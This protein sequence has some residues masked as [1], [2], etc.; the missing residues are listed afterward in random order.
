VFEL[1]SHT[2]HQ[3]TGNFTRFL[4]E[5]ALRVEQ[6][7]AA[8]QKQSAEVAK[9]ERFVERFGAKA[10]KAA[11]ARS[12][13]KKLDKMNILTAPQHHRLPR[14]SLPPAPAGDMAAIKLV[15]VTAGWPD[16][17]D[18]LCNINLTV[19]RGR[20]IAVLGP[21][22]CGKS[23]L[24]AVLSGMLSPN[25][26]RRRVGDRIRIGSFTQDLAAELPG[27]L[28]ALEYVCQT[29]PIATEEQVRTTLGALGL[30][31]EAALRSIK[32]LSGGEKAR[33][34]LASLTTRPNNVLLLDEPT[35]HL[36]T[37]TVE[38]LVRALETYEGAMA[39]VT[40]DRYLVEQI[41]THVVNITG[42][43]LD[44]HEGILPGDLEP[45]STRQSG[46]KAVA[47]GS[48]AHA[49]RKREQRLRDRTVRRI[50]EIE[51][52][53]SCL[54]TEISDLD[55][56]LATSGVDYALLGTQRKQKATLIDE[57]MNEWEQLESSL[58]Q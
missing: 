44:L 4:A 33:V 10:S 53:I 20:R 26:G 58:N 50:N 5:R 42:Q 11:Q 40:H 14:F 52:E 18:I 49:D 55:A 32:E 7:L 37:E 47:S 39:F 56:Q 29:S 27:E 9:L 46:G 35:N 15:D 30:S 38:V 24:L 36:D 31:G 45:K 34:A 57:L 41:A 43:V 48:K 19:E 17:P 13:Q 3:Y 23:T 25:Q 6:Q 1:R 28:T 54:E 12:K 22:G 2:L 21:N 8:T 16:G 51:D